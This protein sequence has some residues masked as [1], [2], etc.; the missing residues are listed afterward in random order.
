[1]SIITTTSNNFNYKSPVIF[2]NTIQNET[3]QTIS[4]DVKVEQYYTSKFTYRTATKKYVST[5]SLSYLIN[6]FTIYYYI[7]NVTITKPSINTDLSFYQ[8]TEAMQMNDPCITSPANKNSTVDTIQ[9][10]YLSSTVVTNADKIRLELFCFDDDE[11]VL[12][13]SDLTITSNVKIIPVY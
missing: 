9:W 8:L 5:Q 4:G 2:T 11:N 1:M 13:I 10:I 6:N 3:T 12:D 7:V